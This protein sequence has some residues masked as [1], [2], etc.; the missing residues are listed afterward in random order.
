VF[1]TNLQISSAVSGAPFQVPASI[2]TC[3]SI[4]A[5]LLGSGAELWTA[6]PACDGWLESRAEVLSQAECSEFGA[7]RLPG[8]RRRARSARILLRLALSRACGDDLP[9]A[10][11][12]FRIGTGGKPEVADGL[13]RLHFNVAH[14]EELAVV[15]VSR[16]RP[17]G[18]DVEELDQDVSETMIE[19]FLAPSEQRALAS[20]TGRR[21]NHFLR[22]WTLKEAYT[23]LIGNGLSADFSRIEFEIA[24]PM[25]RATPYGYADAQFATFVV[26]TAARYCQLSLAI[27]A[28]HLRLV[29][30]SNCSALGRVFS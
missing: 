21:A 13:P 19:A 3:W 24:Q 20:L 9:P 26:R 16:Q 27:A 17:L 8:V 28:P 2:P 12:Q 29:Q 25:L 22:F 23:K 30:G 1:K 4:A 11:W 14:S 5:G 15:T 7:L 18:V 10:A 6:P